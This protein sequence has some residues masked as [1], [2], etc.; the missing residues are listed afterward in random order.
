MSLL[1]LERFKSYPDEKLIA[2]VTVDRDAYAHSSITLIKMILKERGVDLGSLGIQDER[3]VEE[4]LSKLKQ[5][6]NLTDKPDKEKVEP[7]N[8]GKDDSNENQPDKKKSFFGN[9][10]SRKKDKK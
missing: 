5:K 2:M 4:E 10:F 6:A 7:P 3:D 8:S 1:L 9:L